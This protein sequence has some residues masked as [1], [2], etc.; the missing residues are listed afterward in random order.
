MGGVMRIR[1]LRSPGT[2]LILLYHAWRHTGGT[3]HHS[4]HRLAA[5][6]SADAL[7]SQ[8]LLLTD[9]ENYTS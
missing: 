1:K 5:L 6:I 2:G 7:T 3:W 8:L 9:C 4:S